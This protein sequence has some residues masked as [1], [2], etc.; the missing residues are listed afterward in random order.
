MELSNGRASRKVKPDFAGLVAGFNPAEG[1]HR[2]TSGDATL[3]KALYADLAEGFT[4]ELTVSR[5][6][7]RYPM[8]AAAAMA[9]LADT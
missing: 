7:Q 5:N 6:G 2:W 4:L 8:Q 9:P 3:P 1:G